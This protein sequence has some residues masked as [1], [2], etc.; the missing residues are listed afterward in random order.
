MKLNV[1]IKPNE[2]SGATRI[3]DP[4]ELTLPKYIKI[5]IRISEQNTKYYLSF[6]E[7]E[8]LRAKLRDTKKNRNNKQIA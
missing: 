7:R 2:Q 4:A 5:E 6:F 1:F 8:Y 3:K